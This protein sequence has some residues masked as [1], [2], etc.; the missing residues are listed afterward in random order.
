MSVMQKYEIAQVL[1]LAPE[2]DAHAGS[3][4]PPPLMSAL[5]AATSKSVPGKLIYDQQVSS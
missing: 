5:T 2:A 1:F 4:R 3:R